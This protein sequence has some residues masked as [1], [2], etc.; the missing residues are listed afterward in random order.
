MKRLLRV[1][2]SPKGASQRN[3]ARSDKNSNVHEILQPMIDIGYAEISAKMGL[4]A[5]G[6][7]ASISVSSSGPPANCRPV[8]NMEFSRGSDRIVS[9]KRADRVKIVWWD[10]SG[11]CLFS[12]R[13]DED[14]FHWPRIENGV[15]RLAEPQLMALVEGIRPA[16]RRR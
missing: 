6:R 9:D 2:R 7:P 16:W 13:L 3:R 10:G 5:A 1:C 15:I 11:I 14:K 12:K 4:A 8:A